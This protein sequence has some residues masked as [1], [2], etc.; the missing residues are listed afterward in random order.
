MPPHSVSHPA[1]SKAHANLTQL[2]KQKVHENH[3]SWWR[4]ALSPFQML[5]T[6]PLLL[7]VSP[8]T[9]GL[10]QKVLSYATLYSLPLNPLIISNTAILSYP[11]VVA[12]GARRSRPSQPSYHTTTSKTWLIMPR[13]KQKNSAWNHL[14]NMTSA[15]TMVLSV[16]CV[17]LRP[18]SRWN[19]KDV[20]SIR[21]CHFSDATKV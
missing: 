8:M 9:H 11:C 16:R 17:I 12:P 6:K 1:L 7:L 10:V 13:M 14:L 19:F 18:L 15:S 5:W 2:V 3:R 4:Q 20:V 21:S